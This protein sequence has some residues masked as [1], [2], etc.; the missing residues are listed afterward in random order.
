MTIRARKGS[1][2]LI[3]LGML[4][5]M[6]I[7]AVAFS[8]YMR[9][10][11][12][13]SSYLRRTVSS[14]MLVKAAIA[15]AIDEI[16]AAIGNNP[17]PGVGST[18]YQFDSST[19]VRM[20]GSLA[21]RNHWLGR[22]YIGGS[23]TSV[24]QNY[25]VDQD[26]TVST[27]CLEALAYIP[28]PLVNEAR[29]YSRRS[30]A[31]QWHNFSFDSGR[32]A[33]CAIDVSDYFD[34]NSVYANYA[35]SSSPDSRVS[36]AHVFENA[37]HE[38]FE[39]QPS[40]WDSFMENFRSD[41]SKVPLVSLADWN[42]ALYD[43]KPAGWESPFCRYVMNN[44]PNFYD[45]G[46]NTGEEADKIRRMTFVTDG[47][48]PDTSAAASGDE[49]YDLNDSKYQP[50]SKGELE[51][52]N[53]N[54]L[55]LLKFTVGSAKAKDRLKQSICG[56]GYAALFDYLDPNRVPVSL[57]IPTC[58]RI[59][60]VCAI[61]P[62][63]SGT[64]VAIISSSEDKPP[65]EIS[66]TERWAI[67]EVTHKLDGAQLT[68]GL[69][70]AKVV[71]AY[72]FCHNDGVNDSFEVDGKVS[73]FFTSEPMGLRTGNINDSLH[74]SLSP[75][76]TAGEMFNGVLTAPFTKQNLSFT[77]VIKENETDALKELLL[78]SQGGMSG[79]ATA[80]NAAHLLTLT[81]RWKQTFQDTNGDG[82]PDDWLPKDPQDPQQ[83]L[84]SAHSEFPPLLS[85]GSPDPAVSD[86]SELLKLL[87]GGG[88]K[89]FT[90]N[91]AVWVR[92]KHSDKFLGLK[93]VDLVPAC[94]KDDDALNGMSSYMSLGPEGN[95]IAG[96]AYP[97][98]RFD[99]GVSF[100]FGE[101]PEAPVVPEA[102]ISP[103]AVMV[104]D[105]RYNHAPESWFALPDGV[106]ATV[107]NWLQ[108]CHASDSDRDGDIF[109]C[110]SDQGYLQSIYELANLP[111]LTEFYVGTTYDHKGNHGSPANAWTGKSFP[112]SFADTANNG[113]MWKTYDPFPNSYRGLG[114]DFEGAGFVSIGN[115]FKVNPYSNS[116]N[117][118]MAAFANT[119][120]D[121]RVSSTNNQEQSFESMGA[122][123]FN[124]KYAWNEYSSGSKLAWADLEDFCG[125]FM[126]KVR[127]NGSDWETAWKN[128]G[129][130]V[131]DKDRNE[132]I[133]D[134]FHLSG[135][136]DRIWNCDRK[137]LYGFWH[138][139]FAARQQLFL[140][141]ARA[142]P[143][144]MGGGAIGQTPPQLGARAMALVWRDPTPTSQN[145]APH[146]TRIL[147]YRQ[148]D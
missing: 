139:C 70:G 56:L 27:L 94:I 128:L 40:A 99:T 148:F 11:R 47:W 28:P 53:P 140:V 80:V 106:G 75:D 65:E 107:A 74:F 35:R 32:Y 132:C 104:A 57:A 52:T 25:L 85:N 83:D 114:D 147:F 81:Y 55:S 72:P 45:I 119:P 33:F 63:L 19:H 137:F 16:D 3:V 121:W 60:M 116:T 78:S 34:V 42:L 37:A 145:G 6:V 30:R 115:G 120:H 87:R 130:R 5:F 21:N 101:K 7:S 48:F 143:T 96:S 131:V 133:V 88:T 86:D 117:V 138:D 39:R 17:H 46:G 71:F 102:T 10:S 8:A 41:R 82:K 129:W 43:S 146:Q 142:E 24:A 64:K 122:K 20:I 97:V 9:Y 51:N 90:L 67:R 38:G 126:A 59:P 54:L 68:A 12:L 113:L 144:M 98:M 66:Q 4:A 141:F 69:R 118:M 14:R 93:T 36:I 92:I 26:M 2:L 77:T 18:A 13:P 23:G 29:Y 112:L 110:V 108:Y 127:A 50:F 76:G 111:R 95:Q 103:Q 105:P 1:A 15:N 22:I 125:E 84:Q 44:S 109:M 134:S 135:V 61:E 91:A 73:L 58:E 100:V 89:T 79:A 124:S 123:E 31:A 49:D 62:Q 136:S